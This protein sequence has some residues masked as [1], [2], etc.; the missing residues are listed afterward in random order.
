MNLF[1]APE[2][3][4]LRDLARMFEEG[5]SDLKA[6]IEADRVARKEGVEN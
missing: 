2:Q 5:Q 3:E 6:M 1:T 4:G